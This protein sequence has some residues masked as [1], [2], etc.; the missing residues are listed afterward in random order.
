MKLAWAVDLHLVFLTPAEMPKEAK[1]DPFLEKLA[2]L[3]GASMEAV[4]AEDDLTPF[5]EE[6]ASQPFDALAICG[7]ISEAPM[8]ELHLK[9]LAEYL[10]RPIYFV[11]GNH[12][13]YHGS[14]EEVLPRIEAFNGNTNLLHCLEFETW[15]DLTETTGLIGHG[16]WAD[17][18]YG[19]FYTSPTV[20]NDWKVIAELKPAWKLPDVDLMKRRLKI[21][22][23]DKNALL[24]ILHER[25]DQAGDHIRRVLPR[26]LEKKNRVI[27]ITHAPP[28]LP[29]LAPRS[30]RWE[31][32]APHAGCKAAGDA[33]LEIMQDMPGKQLTILSGH[34]HSSEKFYVTDNI[35]QRIGYAEYL[36]PQITDVL[37]L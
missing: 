35:E 1:P 37:E 8:L 29:R 28:F 24:E 21:G 25:G 2:L 20:L 16:C 12:D 15:I 5:L 17:G 13:F 22:E 4:M 3:G 18:R 10:Q 11:L 23:L 32:W 27:L 6:L 31:D 26:V 14:F 36:E 7:D 30:L 33:I 34:I 9:L 19:R